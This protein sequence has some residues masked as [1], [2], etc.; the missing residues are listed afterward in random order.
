MSVVSLLDAN[1]LLALFDPDHIH[2]DIAHDWFGEHGPG[3]WATCPL[4]E[5]GFLRTVNAVRKAD[6]V[7]LPDLIEHLR[8]FQSSGG[9]HRWNDDL[10]LLDERLFNAQTIHG[11]R[12]LTDIYLL[13]L[14]VKRAGRLVTFDHRIPRAA[15]KGA[16]HDHLV[17][18]ATSD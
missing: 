17:V 18:L 15:V 5:N 13:G 2:H 11:R 9:H 7:P 8:R 14:A 3:G 1:V 12:Q 6:F 4:T 16:R 10:T